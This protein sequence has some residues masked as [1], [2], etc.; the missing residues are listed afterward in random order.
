MKDKNTAFWNN[1]KIRAR[2]FQLLVLSFVTLF[3]IFLYVNTKSNLAKQNIASGYGFLSLESGFEIG[4]SVIEYFSDDTY[5]KALW[6]GVLNTLKVAVI[7]NVLAIILGVFIGVARLSSNWLVSTISHVY[8]ESMRN[9][10]LLLQLFFWYA[11]FTEFL[12]GVRDALEPIKGV[13]LSNRGVVFAIPKS[14]PIHTYMFYSFIISIVLSVIIFKTFKKVNMET[15]KSLPFI[16]V[17]IGL[18]VLFP[19]VTWLVGGAPM[20][21][22]TP[23]LRGFNFSGGHTLTPEYSSLL[24]GLVLYT[25][26]FNAEIVRSGIES[27]KS[28]QWEASKSLGLSNSQT[29]AL[30]ILPQALRVI[31]PPITS[32]ILNLTKN[33]S[34]AVAIGYP[35]FVSV[36]N[37]ALNQTGQAVELV[38]LIMAV[39][40]I[41]SLITSIFMNWYNKKTA[42]VER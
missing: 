25:A 20:E 23:A 15:G 22:D 21:L 35:D 7:G 13:F 36:A 26:A 14:N 34:L 3:T 33:S 40:L 10:P 11:I 1:P 30:V 18:I 17:I 4:E 5:H 29:L 27:V 8:I 39:Y 42:L 6:V 32:Q 37:T 9:I 19:L 41:I 2:S 31:I 16:K 12:P 28:G 38:L 24:L